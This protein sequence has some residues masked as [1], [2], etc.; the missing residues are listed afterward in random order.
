M[1]RL[2]LFALLFFLLLYKSSFGKP[3]WSNILGCR[4]QVLSQLASRYPVRLWNWHMPSCYSLWKRNTRASR[5][6]WRSLGT[7]LQTK[8]LKHSFPFRNFSCGH[9]CTYFRIKC[10]G[11]IREQILVFRTRKHLQICHTRCKIANNLGNNVF[12]F[13]SSPRELQ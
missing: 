13:Y 6:M 3:C 8:P 5:L 10:T 1:R 2:K 9:W 11:H 12:L 7:C 4:D